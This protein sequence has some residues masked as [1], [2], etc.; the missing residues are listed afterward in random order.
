MIGV[1]DR[2]G[3]R[4]IDLRHFLPIRTVQVAVFEH[5]KLLGRSLFGTGDLLQQHRR[6]I[7]G[8]I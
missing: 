8:K 2:V 7:V 1:H 6:A 4:E 5:S 3:F